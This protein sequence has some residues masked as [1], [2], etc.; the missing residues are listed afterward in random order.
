MLGPLTPSPKC[1]SNRP[2]NLHTIEITYLEFHPKK[3]AGTVCS[4]TAQVA[5]PGFPGRA[6]WAVKEHIV[7]ADFLAETQD[8][9][10]L[11]Y[12]DYLVS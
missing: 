6:T 2:E 10:S 9:L 5:L 3:P 12:K 4:L 8:M 1:L 11:W 7:P